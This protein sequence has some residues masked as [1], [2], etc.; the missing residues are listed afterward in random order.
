[1]KYVNVTILKRGEIGAPWRIAAAIACALHLI[2]PLN[3]VRDHN[4]LNLR[5]TTFFSI[6]I[7]TSLKNV[8][9]Q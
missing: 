6:S 9:L 8:A 2:I 4:L 7:C 3:I 1:M 5:T